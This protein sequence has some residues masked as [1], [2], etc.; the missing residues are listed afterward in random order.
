MD[1]FGGKAGLWDRLENLI[2]LPSSPVAQASY[3]PSSST[4]SMSSTSHVTSCKYYVLLKYIFHLQAV[5]AGHFGSLSRISFHYPATFVYFDTVMTVCRFLRTKKNIKKYKF[6]QEEVIARVIEGKSSDRRESNSTDDQ[7]FLSYGTVWYQSHKDRKE[8]SNLAKR[9]SNF[10]W[11]SRGPKLKRC[12]WILSF[13][14][15]LLFWFWS[16]QL[17]PP[18]SCHR[19]K[20]DLVPSGLRRWQIFVSLCPIFCQEDHFCNKF[21]DGP[22][23]WESSSHED[24]VTSNQPLSTRVR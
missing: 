19:T 17:Q 21:Y 20:H 10:A 4:H 14:G 13:L 7:P 5:L 3:P 2:Y 23:S 12:D 1:P 16:F 9:K 11:Y 6:K 22:L 15:F 8:T 24:D 18:A